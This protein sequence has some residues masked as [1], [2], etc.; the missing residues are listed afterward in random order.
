MADELAALQSGGGMWEVSSADASSALHEGRVPPDATGN[1]HMDNLLHG[2]GLL[3]QQQKKKDDGEGAD[4]GGEGP[5]GDGPAEDDEETGI[6]R[7]PKR[8]T[9]ERSFRLR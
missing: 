7:K 3:E 9:R 5:G 4:D 6:K 2:V 8:K 1:E